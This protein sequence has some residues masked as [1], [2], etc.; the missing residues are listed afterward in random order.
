MLSLLF[1][2]LIVADVVNVSLGL[3]ARDPL[4]HHGRCEPI[5]IPMCMNIPYNETI[6]PNLM[7]HQKQEEAGLEVHQFLPLVKVKCSPDLQFFLCSMYVPV[8]TILEKAIRPCRSLC[9]SAKAGCE[10]L[11]NRF[12]FLWPDNLECSK[13]PVFGHDEIC[14]GDNNTA[15]TEPSR[16][17]EPQSQGPRAEYHPGWN[18]R[19]SDG[20]DLFGARDFGFVCSMQFQVPHDLG[21]SLKVGDVTEPNCGAPCDDM[22]FTPKERRFSRIWVGTWASVC[23]ASC[24]FTALTFLIDTDRFRYPER[25]IIF[26]SVCYLM[27]A[28]VYVVGWAAG[29]SI[30]CREPFSPPLNVRFET[31]S[32]VTQGTKHEL[33]TVLFMVLYFFSMASSI[34][35]VILTLT[36]FL[37]AGLKWGH[38]AI[39]AHS[40]YFHLAAWAVPA[41]KTITILAMG[42]VE[43]DILSGV[44]YVGLWNVKALRGFV[45]APL[46]VYLVLGTAFLLAG[47]VSLFRIRTVMKHDGTKTDKLEKLMIRIGIFSVLYTVPALIVIACLFYEQAYFDHWMLNWWSEKCIKYSI[48]CPVG[49]RTRD[50]GRRPEFEVFMIKYL[51]AMIVGITSSFWV[52]SSKTLT[53]WRQFFNRIQGRRTEAYV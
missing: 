37:A 10:S 27:V 35:W 25:P 8:C 33:C 14:V 4:E 21:Y 50:L 20:S 36:W 53:S 15:S 42:K 39:E 47:F 44:C 48:P 46:C 43:G 45:L 29:N 5:T 52:W 41:V 9:E 3:H 16:P 17:L 32:T 40:Q 30:S 34:W 38:E 31:I 6:M 22:F 24:F 13:F 19:P 2:Y 51:M 26:L 18:N 28:L 49:E 11:M 23:A 12:G 7:S 1:A